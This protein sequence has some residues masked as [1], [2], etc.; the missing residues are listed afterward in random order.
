MHL[1]RFFSCICQPFRH[2]LSPFQIRLLIFVSYGKREEKELEPNDA[3]LIRLF[4]WRRKKYI[5]TKCTLSRE[6]LWRNSTNLTKNIYLNRTENCYQYFVSGFRYLCLSLLY[7]YFTSYYT[8][9]VHQRSRVRGILH[10]LLICSMMYY[11]TF[12]PPHLVRPASRPF[13]GKNFG[14][15]GSGVVGVLLDEL[16]PPPV[17][18]ASLVLE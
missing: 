9:N 8:S 3:D 14:A 7:V 12:T 5:R 11:F 4:V 10:I 13:S 2:F 1:C 6:H 16:L 18:L 15:V 17:P